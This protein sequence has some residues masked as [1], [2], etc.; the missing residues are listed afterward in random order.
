MQA[1]VSE[2]EEMSMV[3][4]GVPK[5]LHLAIKA[6]TKERGQTIKGFMTLLVK[7]EFQKNNFQY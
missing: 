6:Y 4:I 1:R 2:A 7:N 5:S 3:T